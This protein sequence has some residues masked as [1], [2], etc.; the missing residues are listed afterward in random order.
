MLLE[1]LESLAT[2]CP[3]EIRDLGY[4]R[5]LI[6]IGARQRRCR[7]AWAIHIARSRG[8]ILEAMGL[9]P[10]RRT[11][12][13]LGSGRLLDVP[14]AELAREFERVVLVDALHPLVSRWQAR[15]YQ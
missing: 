9:V 10:R 7:A 5:E 15:R 12:I 4:R 11:A 8:A 2:P 13:V 1:W 6:A 14:L 3:P